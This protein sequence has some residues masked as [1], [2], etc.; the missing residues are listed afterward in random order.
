LQEAGFFGSQKGFSQRVTCVKFIGAWSQEA[1]SFAGWL[2]QLFQ[3]TSVVTQVLF[4][5]VRWLRK[6]FVAQKRPQSM[7]RFT[8]A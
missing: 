7:A 3:S 4:L 2:F 5:Q 8:S 6:P 1:M